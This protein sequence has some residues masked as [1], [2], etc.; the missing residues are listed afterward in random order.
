MRRSVV[1]LALAAAAACAAAEPS[2]AGLRKAIVET[3]LTFR[4]VPY[5]YGAESPN[6]FDCS[7]FVRYVY[8]KATGLVIPRTSKAMFAAGT[9]VKP[10]QAQPGDVLVFDTVGGAPSHVALVLDGKSMI[11]AASAGPVTGVIVSPLSDRYF[12]PRVIGAREFLERATA[13]PMPAPEPAAAPA[14]AKPAPS[15]APAPAKPAAV[16]A[17]AQ[18]QPAKP[19]PSPAA[20]V[21]RPAAAADEPVVSSV[22]FSITNQASIF[23][24][25]IPAATG[26]ALQFAVTN[27]TGADGVFEILFYKMDMDPSK[28]KTLR[29]DRVRIGAGKMVE[30]EPFTF[31]ESGQYKLILKTHDNIK[32][33]ERIWRVVDVK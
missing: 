13:I 12:A 30:V 33:V 5:V 21:S 27:D 2:E 31:T 7:G 6:A 16:P 19:A 15:P 4:G 29:K 3:A 18:T 26:T 10:N 23:T 20:P 17:P 32:R 28:N 14:P 9:P 8:G 11:H 24:D 25:K 22:G 1:A